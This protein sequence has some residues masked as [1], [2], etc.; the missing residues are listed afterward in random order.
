MIT[1]DQVVIVKMTAQEKGLLEQASRKTGM[2]MSD[3]IRQ[4]V[5]GFASSVGLTDYPP[6]WGTKW[7]GPTQ[8]EAVP[9]DD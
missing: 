2:T 3:V 4:G 1:R 8:P 5:R 7:T 6:A 9:D